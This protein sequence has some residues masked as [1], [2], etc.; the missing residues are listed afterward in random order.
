MSKPTIFFS[1]SSKDKDSLLV[2]KK[3]IEKKTGGTIEIFMSSD[4]QSIPFGTNWIHK[5]EYGLQNAKIMFVFITPNSLD[6]SWIYFESGFAY[7]KEI[8]VIPIGIGIDIAQISPPLNLLQGFNVISEDSLN[9]IINIIN[10][11]FDFSFEEN[12]TE[13]EYNLF[14]V[15]SEQFKV[16]S[17]F[18]DI[19]ENISS[20]IFS[21]IDK[22]HKNVKIDISDVFRK[23]NKYF[24]DNDIEV[25]FNKRNKKLLT[26]GLQLSSQECYGSKEILIS[27]SPYNFSEYYKTLNDI[28]KISYD[29]EDI[30]YINIRLNKMYDSFTSD[31]KI[32]SFIN[33]DDCF[34]LDEE[35][36]GYYLFKNIRFTIF[37]KNKNERTSSYRKADLPLDY[38][39]KVIF[40]VGETDVK[41][42][43]ELIEHL[44]NIG[45]IYKK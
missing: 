10:K 41:V 11:K 42:I 36:V 13:K 28:I 15:D 23:V 4:G 40:K 14:A 22:S 45:I 26:Y 30:H 34:S 2:L 38:V 6:S 31:I 37:D 8:E 44:Y 24:T 27:I 19:V 7:S 33:K 17:L 1:H 32:S 20:T 21:Y 16:Q 5:I 9:N 18:Y 43:Y 35:N 25:S 3:L 39:I 12:F 29:N